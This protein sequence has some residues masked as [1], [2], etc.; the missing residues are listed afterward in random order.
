M[1]VVVMGDLN[2]GPGL[3]AFEKVVG[4]SF[5]K[6]VLGSVFEPAGIFHN[7]LWGMTGTSTTRK[8][9]WTADFDDPIVTHPGGWK[10]R[11]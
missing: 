11:V 2:D 1:P 3:D 4:R 7:T 9:L 10:H 6:T 5:V 8:Q